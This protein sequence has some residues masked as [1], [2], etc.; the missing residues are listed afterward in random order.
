MT[1]IK[2][3]RCFTWRSLFCL[4]TGNSSIKQQPNMP[5]L[6]GIIMQGSAITENSPSSSK[7]KHLHFASVIKV[8]FFQTL[9]SQKW[10]NNLSFEKQA[11]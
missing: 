3:A 9:L 8:V 6:D 5:Q 1:K 2:L 7:W 10:L 4:D 11:L